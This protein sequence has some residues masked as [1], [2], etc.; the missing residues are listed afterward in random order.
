MLRKHLP[1]ASKEGGGEDV[2]MHVLEV[3][4]GECVLAHELY[5]WLRRTLLL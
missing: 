2:Q 1:E 4:S 5:I 3:G